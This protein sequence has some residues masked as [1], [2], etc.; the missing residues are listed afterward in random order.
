MSEAVGLAIHQLPP[1]DTGVVVGVVGVGCVIVG[2]GGGMVGC[3]VV[4]VGGE[5]KVG[6]G[7]VGVGVVGAGLTT[8][9]VSNWSV[10]TES[11]KGI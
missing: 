10:N 5:L 9:I 3:V 8:G 1:D 7:V 4:G 6:V 11:E 2:V